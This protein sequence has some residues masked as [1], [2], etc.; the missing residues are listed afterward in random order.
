MNQNNNYATVNNRNNFSQQQPNSMHHPNM[1]YPPQNNYGPPPPQNIMGPPPPS[2]NM[3]PPS[4]M[5]PPPQNN[6]G[7]PP[8]MGPPMGN[9]QQNGQQQFPGMKQN[10][11]SNMPPQQQGVF[12]L[13][14]LFRMTKRVFLDILN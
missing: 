12:L 4:N 2:N 10:S 14:I 9:M 8:Q 3:R 7:P 11:F 6:A 13:V 1:G 5:G